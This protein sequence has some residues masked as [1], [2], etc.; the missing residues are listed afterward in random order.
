VERR[1]RFSPL[2]PGMKK[3]IL[4]AMAAAMIPLAGCVY[5]PYPYHHGYYGDRYY[6]GYY[7]RDYRDN[8]N[9]DRYYD[10]DG[11]RDGYYDRDGYR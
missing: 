7:R 2:E 6:D 8:G 5:R 1:H 9:R 10:R 11:Y 4:L 3:L